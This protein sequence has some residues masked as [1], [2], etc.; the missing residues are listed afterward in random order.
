MADIKT[1]DS[2]PKTIKTLNKAVVGTQNIKD[3]LVSTK[4]KINDNTQNKNEENN[5]TLV[6]FGYHMFSIC[7]RDYLD[8]GA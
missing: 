6:S 2:K 8:V 5:N 7:H 4:E 1:K 3:N